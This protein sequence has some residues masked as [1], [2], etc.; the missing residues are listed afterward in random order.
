MWTRSAGWL[1]RAADRVSQYLIRHV[2]YE[3]DQA[4]EEVVFRVLLFKFFNKV[5]TWERLRAAFS[6]P[7]ARSLEVARQPLVE[8]VVD[9]LVAPKLSHV[10]V[11]DLGDGLGTGGR[12]DHDWVGGLL[13]C[14]GAAELKETHRARQKGGDQF[15]D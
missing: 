8:H 13:Q 4:M 1:A 6:V 15:D 11:A 3:G 7:S 5:G 10:D 12:G 14:P 2:A 9:L